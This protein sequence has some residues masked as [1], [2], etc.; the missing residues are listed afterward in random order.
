M[1][2]QS[3]I[4]FLKKNIE[5]NPRKFIFL[6]F[7]V[8]IESLFVMAS[9]A[10]VV[11]FADFIVDPE[12]KNANQFTKYVIS[13][14]SFYSI[15]LNYISFSVLFVITVILTSIFSAL[16]LFQ[17]YKIVMDFKV[18]LANDLLSSILF[19]KWSHLNS[20]KQGQILNIFTKEIQYVGSATR[21][22]AQ[23]FS[24]IFKLFIYLYVPFLI[25]AK[26]TLQVIITFLIIGIP[27]LYLSNYAKRVGE[28]RTIHANSTIDKLSESYHAIKLILGFNLSAKT[29][30]NNLS[31][32]K[33]LENLELK[34]VMLSYI[35]PLTFKPAAIVVILIFF[36]GTFS[37]AKIPEFVGIFWGM[38]G[39]I[40]L[41]STILNNILLTSNFYPS[42][43]QID[44][45]I[46]DCK[47]YP[48]I[49]KGKKF[50]KL[51]KKIQLENVNFGY[52]DEKI[53][54]KNCNLDILKNNITSFV[55]KTGIGKSTIID[56]ILGL[57][58]PNSGIIYYD[59][60]K[61]D[62]I[63][64]K[65]IRDRVGLVP[66]DPLLF[67]TTIKENI[68]W[69]NPE[70][71]DDAILKILDK[72]DAKN[73]VESSKYGLD[74]YVGERGLNLSGGQ[75]QKIALARALAKKPNILIL[76]EALSSIDIKSSEIISKYLKELSNFVTIINITHE[77]DHCKYSDKV[78]LLKNKSFVEIKNSE[79]KPLL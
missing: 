29:K 47:N 44:D 31:M 78:F 26:F 39:A 41:V 22:T 8:I 49:D 77:I 59:N 73:F 46:N 21:A 10:A 38:Y 45:V 61:I 20:L 23:I 75:R 70:L 42:F 2:L 76:D 35:I 72:I 51:D 15:N 67:N 13:I 25:N 36:G 18:S 71:D 5:R 66:Q 65:S 17:I 74:T 34:A 32:I 54:I 43:K 4:F 56:L 19:S 11:P 62:N 7:L 40:P 60:H 79:F 37:T 28:K 1:L 68:R 30:K 55:G 16:I 52:N 69:A 33:T 12:L 64:L 63:N 53:F 57:Q 24:N 14:F 6:I 48:E 58:S 3:L 50:N 9:F 27:F